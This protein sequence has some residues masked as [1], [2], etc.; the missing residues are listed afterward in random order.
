MEGFQAFNVFRE[1]EVA[2]SQESHNS[3]V[4]RLGPKGFE[5]CSS[6]YY[7]YYYYYSDYYYYYCYYYY[8][9]YYYH[10]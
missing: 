6:Y 2:G 1:E 7:Y 4:E 8:Y 3:R 5:T 9:Y 10:Y